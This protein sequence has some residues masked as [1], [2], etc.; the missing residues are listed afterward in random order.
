MGFQDLFAFET[1]LGRYTGA[2][3]VVATDGCTHA[4]EL[5]MRYYQIKTV[6]FSAYTYISI[7]QT[8]CNLGIR[9]SMT[10]ESWIGE[11]RFHG[12]NI[13]DAARCLEPGMYRTGHI[14]CLSFGHSKPLQIGRLGAVLLDDAEGYR[15]ISRMRSDGRDLRITPW[16]DQKIFAAGWHYCPSLEDCRKGLAL[17]PDV[18]AQ[19]QKVSYPDC[20][21]ISITS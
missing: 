15:Q 16:Q 8:M 2:P 9:Y 18:T 17:L 21:K 5:V 10:D 11:Y 13:W 3:Y 1:A 12:T 20:R 4:I 7:P 6:E 14:Q 19:R